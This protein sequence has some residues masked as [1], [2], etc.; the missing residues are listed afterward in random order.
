MDKIDTLFPAPAAVQAAQASQAGQTTQASGPARPQPPT[1]AAANE[2]QRDADTVDIAAIFPSR[3]IRLVID[4]ATGI[5]QAQVRD[6]ATGR[7]LRKLPDDEW[8]K[9]SAI[10][11]EFASQAIIDKSA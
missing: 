3:H 8:L 11:R 9:E 4:E 7:V 6:A 1:P 10:L 2:H 5:V